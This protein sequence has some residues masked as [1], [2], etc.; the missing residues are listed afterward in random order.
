MPGDIIWGPVNTSPPN[1]LL[2][3]YGIGYDQV[4]DRIYV[5]EF[6]QNYFYIF[7]SD[8]FLTSYGTLTG[9]DNSLTGLSYSPYDDKFW[10]SL[11]TIPESG[12]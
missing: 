10:C 11:E 2:F 7:S 12:E 5:C 6:K 8:S 4:G 9:P 1:D 3:I